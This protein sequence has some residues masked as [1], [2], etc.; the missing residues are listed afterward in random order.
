MQPRTSPGDSK[1][2]EIRSHWQEFS[3]MAAANKTKQN[4]TDEWGYRENQ[5]TNNHSGGKRDENHNE[6][7]A[8]SLLIEMVEVQESWWKCE[9]LVKVS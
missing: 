1:I 6:G 9:R 7:L 5:T 8:H 3:E 2:K 4:K